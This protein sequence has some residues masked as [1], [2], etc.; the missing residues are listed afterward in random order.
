MGPKFII[1][2]LRSSRLQL[3]D[4]KSYKTLAL[5][6][7]FFLSLGF[8]GLEASVEVEGFSVVSGESESSSTQGILSKSVFCSISSSS[9]TSSSAFKIST[10]L[11]KTAFIS[12]FFSL[13]NK[14]GF[15]MA[16]EEEP[17]RPPLEPPLAPRSAP[18][19]LPLPLRVVS[20][21]VLTLLLWEIEK[22]YFFTANL[23]ISSSTNVFLFL[24]TLRL[25]KNTFL[26]APA[27]PPPLPP[28]VRSL[29]GVREDSFAVPFDISVVEDDSRL[30]FVVALVSAALT[31][32]VEVGFTVEAG[33]L[34]A[35]LEDICL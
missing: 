32:A 14:V 33:M 16:E 23:I 31:A 6:G 10:S 34:L 21:D 4:I 25:G 1:L 7:F 35:L 9:S 12:N 18:R 27:T 2:P 28:N 5:T 15:L 29:A 17:P 20:F 30:I 8:A 3:I 22:F 11:A 13:F 26:L 19:P 24:T